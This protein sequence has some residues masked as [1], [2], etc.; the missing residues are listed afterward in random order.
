MI[1]YIFF[2]LACNSLFASC[3]DDRLSKIH[4]SKS[5]DLTRDHN[6]YWPNLYKLGLKTL[7]KQ[8]QS[9]EILNKSVVYGIGSD[10]DAVRR[11]TIV[12]RGIIKA[13]KNDWYT[14]C[15]CPGAVRDSEYQ[16]RSLVRT[17]KSKNMT[18][19]AE[20]MQQLQAVDR[21]E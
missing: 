21:L 3:D 4:R 12:A 9:I 8:G 13:D 11:W 10:E 7:K 14:D 19:D 17:L 18:L 2:I 1:L 6:Q 20:T 15:C 16:A 5:F